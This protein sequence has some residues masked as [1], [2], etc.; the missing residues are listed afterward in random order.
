MLS[1]RILSTG[2][3]LKHYHGRHKG[4]ATSYDEAKRLTINPAKPN[5]FRKYDTGLGHEKARK[6]ALDLIVSNNLKLSLVES[7]SF[8]AFVAGHNPYV[9]IYIYNNIFI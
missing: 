6:L 9:L 3:L 2:N 4:I 5:F 1:H 7:L 8:Q